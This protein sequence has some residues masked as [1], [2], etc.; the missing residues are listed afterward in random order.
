MAEATADQVRLA[1]IKE[2]TYGVQVTGSNLQTLRFTSEDLGHDTSSVRSAEIRNDREVAD[3]VRTNIGASGSV[4][5]ELAL[6][7]FNDWLASA[8]GDSA[9][10]ALVTVDSADTNISFTAPDTITHATAWAVNPT[11]Y[12]WIKV[13]G[14]ATAANN[15]YFKVATVTGTVITTDQQTLATEGAGA[16]VTIIQGPYIENGT[17]LDTYNIEREYTDL[18]SELELLLGMGIDTMSL[19]ISPEAIVSASFGFLGSKGDSITS[20]GGTGYDAASTVSPANAVDDVTAIQEALALTA[21]ASTAFTLDISNNIRS[22]LQ[23]GTLG[24]VSLGAGKINVSGTLQAY[25]AAKTLID[26][27]QD[28]T[29][30]NL[31]VIFEDSESTPNGLVID[32]PS[33]KYTNGRRVTG[34]ENTDIIGAM[35]WEGFRDATE[36][37]T[38]R[39]ARFPT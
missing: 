13:S 9:W 14:A 24:S 35:D 26:K 3:I 33:V 21:F 23:I 4:N 28:W 22:R 19:S 25:Y 38:I 8:I 1:Y 39:I 10:S 15:G 36:G 16:S 5:V 2:S 17:T 7:T 20:S 18:S 27:F 34:G 6:A 12:Q 31:A 32:I 37:I 29:S 30:S 11:Q